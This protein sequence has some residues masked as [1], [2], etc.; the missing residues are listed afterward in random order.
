MKNRKRNQFTFEFKKDES[1]FHRFNL[2]IQICQN[3]TNLDQG[4]LF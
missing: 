4:L 3:K 2:N 1:L